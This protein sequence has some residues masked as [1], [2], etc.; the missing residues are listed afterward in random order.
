MKKI[1]S[2]PY[3]RY[4]LLILIGVL[5]GW[6]AF[7]P[8]EIKPGNTENSG[9]SDQ[10]NIWTCAMHPEVRR[11]EP[12]KCPICGMDL[13][14]LS[15]DI[16]ADPGAIHL[17]SE[18]LEL[19]KVMTSVVSHHKAVKEVRLFG[20]IQADERSIQSQVSHI[21]GRIE[22]LM[23]NFTGEK[24]VKGQ[25]LASVN[26]P[27]LISAQQELIESAKMKNM[28]PEIYKAA[29]EKLL[30]WKLSENQVNS[31]ENSGMIQNDFNVL[32]NSAGIVTARRVNQGDY[33]SQ[34]SIL[35]E[36]TDLSRVWAMFDAYESDLPFVQ[37][38]DEI[39]FSVQAL[40]GI[41][42]TSRIAFIDPVI[43]PVTRV[44]K[45]R[46]EIQN[47]SGSLKPEMFATG[48]IKTILDEYH[49]KMIIPKSAVLWTGKRSVVYVKIKGTNES[50]FKMREIDLGPDLD[51]FY[52]VL[53]G[54]EEGEEIVTEGTFAIDA[55]AQL[56]GKQSMMNHAESIQKDN[57]TSPPFKSGEKN[58]KTRGS[59]GSE[60]NENFID[61]LK[62]IYHY[63]LQ[64]KDALVDSD[65]QK[66]N[67]SAKTLAD[68]M[69]KVDDS[70][71]KIEDRDLWAE[72]R[73]KMSKAAGNLA[74][75]QELEYQRDQ[76]PELT[77]GLAKSI[78][79]FGIKGEKI[80]YQFCPMASDYKGDYW[81]SDEAK[82]RNPYFGDQMLTCGS[83]E[84]VFTK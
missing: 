41:R 67:S 76:L 48:I 63:Y 10:E 80:Y 12:G 59:M 21:P 78:R 37:R 42:F 13:V 66:A 38:G 68:F 26:S 28:Q 57:S 55:A 45:L 79:H 71:L 60:S 25:A 49:D 62:M 53:S 7:G 35:Y 11:N 47:S 70:T 30:Q 81:L 50:V 3:F 84:E 34:G 29:R 1:F 8:A 24:V 65:V 82:I 83:V 75:S 51:S 17:T 4:V 64:V 46:A 31:I 2:N 33:I 27:E 15:Q 40:P 54:L 52:V 77:A 61:N 22:K 43:D 9:V 36:V 73:D 14:P 5:I 39:E 56:A 20:K 19:G 44:A 6:I 69:Q 58:S 16:S 23:I 72:S 18:A 74:R 32:S